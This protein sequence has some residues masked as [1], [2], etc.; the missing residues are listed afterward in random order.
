MGS[1]FRQQQKPVVDSYF[2]K[3]FFP[4]STW[5]AYYIIPFSTSVCQRRKYFF[6]DDVERKT[7]FCKQP[8]SPPPSSVFTLVSKLTKVVSANTRRQTPEWSIPLRRKYAMS[9]RR[10]KEGGREGGREK[11]GRHR[12]VIK[13]ASLAFPSATFD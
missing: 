1:Q 7:D 11:E 2:R 8:F 3:N 12:K 10:K 6:D 4:L 5:L 9:W 13:N